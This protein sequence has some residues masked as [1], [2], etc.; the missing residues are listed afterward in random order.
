MKIK[1]IINKQAELQNLLDEIDSREKVKSFGLETILPADSVFLEYSKTGNFSKVKKY[2]DRIYDSKKYKQVAESVTTEWLKVEHDFFKDLNE[3]TKFKP[4]EYQ[5]QITMYG[6][7]G[8]YNLPNNVIVRAANESDVV[9]SADCIKHEI[10]HLMVEKIVRKYKLTH[11]KKEMLVNLIVDKI[12]KRTQSKN[13]ISDKQIES[14]L[15]K[16]ILK[17]QN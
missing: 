13:K 1:L 9:S 5:V 10:I 11:N 6:P 2:L 7:G 17:N 16:E 8:S 3:R 15:E 12:F 14:I 4:I